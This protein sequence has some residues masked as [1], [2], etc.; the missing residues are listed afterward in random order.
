MSRSPNPVNRSHST[1]YD[2][3][4]A[5]SVDTPRA[6]RLYAIYCG[7]EN[8]SRKVIA[9]ISHVSE[10]TVRR[11]FAAWNQGGAD[12]LLNKPRHR[13]GRKPKLA[14]E[15]F[16]A[17]ILPLIRTADGDVAP[18]WSLADVQRKAERELGITIS[19]SALRR[20][21]RKRGLRPRRQPAA[22]SSSWDL[23]WPEQY[24]RS[25]SDYLQKQA[26]NRSQP[27]TIP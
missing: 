10:R 14:R 22:K 26:S 8:L 21:F 25:L 1:K 19:Y 27:S 20:Y 17:K 15:E 13:S 18:F 24:G 11:W 5:S 16:E 6:T 3:M 12:L 4:V 9:E 23:P 2:L 7:Y